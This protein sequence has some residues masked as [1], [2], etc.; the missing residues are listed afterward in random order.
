MSVEFSSRKEE[1]RDTDGKRERRKSF[2]YIENDQR[3]DDRRNRQRRKI[4]RERRKELER[5]KKA[6]R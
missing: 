6:Q 1:R 2:T 4:D 3:K 5:H